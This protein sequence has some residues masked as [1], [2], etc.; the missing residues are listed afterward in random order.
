MMS[1]DWT[2]PSY[3]ILYTFGCWY[4][5]KLFRCRTSQE[6]AYRHRNIRQASNFSEDFHWSLIS[7]TV[8]LLLSRDKVQ[9]AKLSRASFH[10]WI[11]KYGLPMPFARLS[12]ENHETL[13]VSVI[14]LIVL[15][16][17]DYLLSHIFNG[18]QYFNC[19]VIG[20]CLLSS[21]CQL[22]NVLLQ[23]ICHI[24]FIKSLRET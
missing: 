15:S 8:S 14:T 7:W 1:L 11:W 21:L 20:T 12:I 24:T 16:C 18:Y 3:F 4:N 2:G 19:G 17:V 22:I 23:V 9:A 6:D 10:K 13:W 5:V